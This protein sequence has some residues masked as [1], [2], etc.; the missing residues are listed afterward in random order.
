MI[1]QETFIW[2]YVTP[3]I[4]NTNEAITYNFWFQECFTNRNGRHNVLNKTMCKAGIVM[5]V[6]L[7]RMLTKRLYKNFIIPF[8][9]LTSIFSL[10][11]EISLLNF[12]HHFHSHL[13]W[14]L[15]LWQ[16]L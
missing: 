3:F 12:C 5:I 1:E 15:P 2:S 7:H 9:N 8:W 4:R 14:K 13:S 16:F 6:H 10:H 11:V